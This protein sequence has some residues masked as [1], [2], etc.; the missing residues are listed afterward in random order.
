MGTF[1]RL[2]GYL[3]KY[4]HLV[5]LGMFAVLVAATL[6]LVS[7]LIVREVV[8]KVLI[9]KQY[10]I[11]PLYT[12]SI[13]G[14][15][16]FRGVFRFIRRYVQSYVGQRV[17]FDIRTDLFKALQ[18]KSFSFYDKR[19]TGQLMSR[20]TNDVERVRVLQSWWITAITTSILT[21]VSIT[22]ILISLNLKL[23]L[24]STIIFPPIFICAYIL[25]KTIRPKYREMRQLMGTMTSILQENI[26]GTRV[27]RAF[28]REDFERGKFGEKNTEYLDIQLE[29]VKLR[30]TYGPLM[31]LMLSFGI[32]IVYWFGG[33]EAIRGELSIGTLVAFASYLSMLTNPVRFLGFLI[34]FY[35]SAMTGAERIFEIIDFQTEVKENPKAIELPPI[36]GTVKIEHVNFWY[37]S[38]H[39][40]IEDLNLTVRS[41]ETVALL[42]ATGSGKSTVTHLIPRF[43]DVI[44]GRVLVDGIDVRDVTLKS[45]RDQIGIVPQ[46]TFLFSTTIRENIAFGKPNA[47]TEEIIRAAKMAKAHDFITS[48]PDGYETIVGER[49]ATLSGGQKQRIALARALIR[50]PR[51]LIMDDSTSSVDVDTEQEIQEAIRNLLKERTAFIITQRLSTIKNAD[52]IVVLE[53]G[54]I[55]EEGTH[56]ELMTRNGIY[57]RIY[58]TQLD[59]ASYLNKEEISGITHSR[60]R[61]D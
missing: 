24:L 41:G 56:E 61:R 34:T 6:N 15:S 22:A 33:G 4:W 8:D 43:Y 50:D 35:T 39:P 21:T 14:V 7:P 12:L 45:L 13:V 60:E 32:I 26:V 17:V 1:T 23:T 37:D 54:R 46:E 16:V 3:R 2:M 48:F 51:I 40:I 25:S 10:S 29:T 31:N 18:E 52:R 19:R 42:G 59:E 36:K 27:V 44:S 53:D 57:T 28:A 58:E 30:A 11:L 47:T 55:S 49:G 9:E 5:S 20:A 38:D